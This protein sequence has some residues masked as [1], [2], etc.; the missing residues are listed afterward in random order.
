MEKTQSFPRKTKSLKKKKNFLLPKV[1]EFV[2]API[3]A[4]GV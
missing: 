1:E 2:F 3:A 4:K